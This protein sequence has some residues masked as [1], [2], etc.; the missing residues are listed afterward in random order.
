MIRLAPSAKAP[1]PGADDGENWST[2]IKRRF[3]KWVIL[4][5]VFFLP[6]NNIHSRCN[7]QPHYHK[8]I[9]LWIISHQLSTHFLHFVHFSLFCILYE[10]NTPVALIKSILLIHD[11]IKTWIKKEQIQERYD[12]IAFSWTVTRRA[13]V[14]GV[15]R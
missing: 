10:F 3:M 14:R 9:L 2:L 1:I 6:R 7:G 8:D 5:L 11:A 15:R 13:A 12:L 4:P